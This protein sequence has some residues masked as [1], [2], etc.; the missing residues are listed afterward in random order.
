M[1]IKTD[2][3]SLELICTV[4]KNSNMGLTYNQLVHKLQ[5]HIPHFSWVAIYLYDHENEKYELTAG[6]GDPF[7][8]PL[9]NKSIMHIHMK[10]GTR[11]IGKFTVISKSYASLDES[12]YSS[13]QTLAQEL[14]EKIELPEHL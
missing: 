10:K 3:L 13:L 5:S 12:D 11:S 1:S 2:L 9:S 7:P 8:L 14:S 4:H 6:A